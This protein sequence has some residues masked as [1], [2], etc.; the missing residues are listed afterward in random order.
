MVL[1]F[2]A[3]GLRGVV[4]AVDGEPNME[5]ADALPLALALV[6]PRPLPIPAE[7]AASYLGP[8]LWQSPPE[9]VWRLQMR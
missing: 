2:F 4:S 7:M 9:G 3:T 5:P 6:L 1:F 8:H